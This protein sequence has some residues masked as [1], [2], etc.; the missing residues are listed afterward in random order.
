M[1]RFVE[2]KWKNLGQVEVISLKNGVFLFLFE[3]AE[4]R[5]S[6]GIVLMADGK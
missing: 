1:K 5:E 6:F 2:L 3:T 4:Y